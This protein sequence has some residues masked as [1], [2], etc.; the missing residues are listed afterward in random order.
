MSKTKNLGQ[1]T[2]NLCEKLIFY[3]K[4][5]VKEKS[6]VYGYAYVYTPRLHVY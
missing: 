2:Q 5:L 6:Y 4:I 3:P 1:I